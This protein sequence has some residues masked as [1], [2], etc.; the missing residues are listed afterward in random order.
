[1]KALSCS[2]ACSW[3]QYL[4]YSSRG[5]GAPPLPILLT[6]KLEKLLVGKVLHIGGW[7]SAKTRARGGEKGKRTANLLAPYRLRTNVGSIRGG[8][9]AHLDISLITIKNNTPPN[10]GFVDSN[11]MRSLDS[12]HNTRANFSFFSFFYIYMGAASSQPVNMSASVVSSATKVFIEYCG[13]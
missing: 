1:L 6:V 2:P 12:Q 10:R 7:L 8:M 5:L 11:R 13:R 3:L 9:I 4:E